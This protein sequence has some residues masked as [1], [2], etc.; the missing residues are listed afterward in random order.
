MH[1]QGEPANSEP[2]SSA[3]LVSPTADDLFQPVKVHVTRACTTVALHAGGCL[4]SNLCR[5][6][7]RKG[8]CDYLLD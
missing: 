8:D 6:G 3:F 2:L 7:G 1:L 4:V 5:K